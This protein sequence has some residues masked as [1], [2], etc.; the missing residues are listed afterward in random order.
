MG[1]DDPKKKTFEMNIQLIGENLSNYLNS[2]SEAKNKNSIQNCWKFNYDNNLG[3]DAQ[4]NKYFDKLQ[5]IKQIIKKDKTISLKE[6]LLVRI[7][8]IFDPIVTSIISKVNEL[9]QTQY[10]PIVL[11]LL[12]NDFSTNMNFSIDEKKYKRIEPRLIM[13]TKYDEKNPKYIEPLLLRFCSIHNELGD[14]FTVGEG[15]NEEDYD[16]IE[17][18]YPFNI[19][20]ACIGRFGQ[21]KSTGVNVILDEYKAKES[22]KGSSQT[23][24]LTF[25]QAR[26]QPIRLIFILFYIF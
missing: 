7:K 24:G 26:D 23:L 9:G 8:E 14:R 2:I 25:Y 5:Q 6:C 22:A 10:M 4:I 13:I 17:H 1:N 3:V 15:E 16:L 12:E 19:N 21:G 20:I 11:F 18:Y